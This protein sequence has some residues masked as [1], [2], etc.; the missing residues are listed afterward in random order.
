MKKNKAKDGIVVN[1]GNGNYIPNIVRGGAAI[2]IGKK[3]FYYMQGRKHEQGGIDVGRNAKTGLEVEGEEVMQVTPNEVRVYSSVPFL[4]GVSPAE[5]VLNGADANKVFAAQEKYKNNNRI[6]DDGTKYKYGGINNKQYYANNNSVSFRNN[7]KNNKTKNQKLYNKNN[8]IA[9]KYLANNDNIKYNDNDNINITNKSKMGKLVSI[10]GNVKNGLIHTPNQDVLAYNKERKPRFNGRYSK[11]GLHN[12]ELLVSDLILPKGKVNIEPDVTKRLGWVE[13]HNRLVGSDISQKPLDAK[14][15]NT[16]VAHT[17]S[18]TERRTRKF[19]CGGRS[20]AKTGTK[21]DN[22]IDEIVI[23]AARPKLSAYSVLKDNDISNR[24]SKK[25]IE[26]EVYQADALSSDRLKTKIDN[27]PYKEKEID[28][29]YGDRIV[30]PLINSKSVTKAERNTNIRGRINN[31]YDSV[32]ELLNRVRELGT[33]AQD[34]SN[35][36]YIP[37]SSPVDNYG[38]KTFRNNIT[39]DRLNRFGITPHTYGNGER[40]IS[41]TSINDNQD[42]IESINN[43][44]PRKGTNQSSSSSTGGVNNRTSKSTKPTIQ[45][46]N[47]LAPATN[48]EMAGI[49]RGLEPLLQNTIVDKLNKNVDNDLNVMPV[50]DDIVKTHNMDNIL[51][52]V[53]LGSSV[54]DA[55]MGN[56]Y[57]NQ[58]HGYTA[59]NITAPTIKN[60][61]EIKLNE[62]DLKDIPAPILMAAAKLKTRYNANPQLSKIEDDTRRIM[63]EIGRNTSNSR[64][65]LARKQRAA[66]QGQQA[67]NEVYG[68]KENIETELINKDKLN[69]QEV[70]ARN[71]ARYDQYNQ[72]LAA[73]RA[74]RARLRLAADT[75][76]IQNKLAVST[77]NAQLKSQADRFN[78]ANK[79]NQL[80]HQAGID[81]AKAEARSNIFSGML[82]NI[83]SALNTWNRNK[84]QAKLDE[85][86][87]RVLGLLAPNANK[88]VLSALSY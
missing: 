78:T 37:Y 32:E 18:E 8:N 42:I 56:I 7:N 20:N 47:R 24:H 83:G 58:M 14:K 51:L 40:T 1:V 25:V 55:V 23:N 4:R 88:L 34:K 2:P 53:N 12:L 76:N 54:L 3:N 22:V 68:R 59:P 27:T 36:Y 71:L 43:E 44:T 28:T 75:A 82:G 16:N 57:A 86:T 45:R 30:T 15:D 69:Q 87:L 48:A 52:G 13:V 31:E 6:N 74:N 29:S 19:A 73:Q 17:I 11:P 38:E 81:A 41:N 5:L 61:G 10:N 80:V 72:A 26:R 46:V 77:A 50:Q 35:K 67:K 49:R 33:D 65:A 60:P 79:I 63:G 9:F 64:V 70:T 39:L 62:E 66:L 85:E 84:R 21:K